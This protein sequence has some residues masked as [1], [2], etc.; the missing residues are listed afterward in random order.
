LKEVQCNLVLWAHLLVFFVV[1]CSGHIIKNILEISNNLFPFV[2][3]HQAIS[4][5]LKQFC[6]ITFANIFFHFI[7]IISKWSHGSILLSVAKCSSFLAL[8]KAMVFPCYQFNYLGFLACTSTIEY[9]F[10]IMGFF[11]GLMHFFMEESLV[12]LVCKYALTSS[13]FLCL[14][15]VPYTTNQTSFIWLFCKF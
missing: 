3:T 12:T 14:V 2:F 7:T 13:W 1:S 9:K 6:N 5:V 8:I 10:W 4:H 11:F 15:F